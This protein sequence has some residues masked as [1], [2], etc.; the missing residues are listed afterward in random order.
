[1]NGLAGPHAHLLTAFVTPLA[2]ATAATRPCAVITAGTCR[3]LPALGCRP[4]R[5]RQ[6]WL[7][8]GLPPL[9]RPYRFAGLTGTTSATGFNSP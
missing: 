2:T 9:G 7:R 8:S 6:P 3:A 5:D 1:M 4:V